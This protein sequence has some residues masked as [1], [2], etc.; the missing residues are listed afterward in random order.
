MYTTF[1][2]NMVKKIEFTKN[3][4]KQ[5]EKIVLENGSDNYFRISVKGGGCSWFKYSFTFDKKIQ[6]DDHV[7][8]KTVIDKNSLDIAGWKTIDAYSNEVNFLITNVET[9]ILINSKMFKIPKEE[10]L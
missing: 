5:I 4:L 10:D 7:F 1:F 9:N 8:N 6:K 2:M 3:A